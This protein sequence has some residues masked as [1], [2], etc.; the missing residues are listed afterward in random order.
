M[1]A[2]NIIFWR[3]GALWLISSNWK[4]SSWPTSI[5]L[6]PFDIKKAL[7]GHSFFKLA[8]GIGNKTYIFLGII[9]NNSKIIF[10]K[11]I[12]LS[13]FLYFSIGVRQPIFI[14]KFHYIGRRGLVMFSVALQYLLFGY[15]IFHRNKR[16][17]RGMGIMNKE[18]QRFFSHKFLIIIHTSNTVV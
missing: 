1:H 18:N 16:R 4:F 8:V 2:R 10:H 12:S 9:S 3:S 17:I 13:Y 11:F 14:N 5:I 7:N 6:Q 15:W